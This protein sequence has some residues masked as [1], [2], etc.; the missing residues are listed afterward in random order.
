MT[1]LKLIR[2]VVSGNS[3][4]TGHLNKSNTETNLTIA[5][6][7]MHYLTTF[8]CTVSKLKVS[9]FALLKR[10]AFRSSTATATLKAATSI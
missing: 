6:K 4:V 5:N 1:S 8:K 3:A 10:A 9:I 2:I 7:I